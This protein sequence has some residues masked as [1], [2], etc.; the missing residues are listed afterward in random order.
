[1]S[2]IELERFL[3]GR[4]VATL[5]TLGAD[6]A[7]VPTP[8]WYRH[9]DGAFYFR[10]AA[11][12]VKTENVRRDPRVSVCVQDERPPYRAVIAHGKA[13]IAAPDDALAAHLPRHY[14]GLVGALGY[15][16]AA[17]GAIERGPEVTL[18]VRPERFSTFDFSAE[19]PRAGRIWLF[20]KRFLPPW[21]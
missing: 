8:V 13:E 14:L 1:M 6:G 11:N 12:A 2:P 18:I 19:T 3:A 10:T 15:R 20:A 4:H 21:L 5:V 9:L 17:R 7:P 16:A